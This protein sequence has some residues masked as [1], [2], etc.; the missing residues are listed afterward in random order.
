MVAYFLLILVDVTFVV[1]KI[2]E[3]SYQNNRFSLMFDNQKV[4]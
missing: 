2:K 4:S 3:M 1:F